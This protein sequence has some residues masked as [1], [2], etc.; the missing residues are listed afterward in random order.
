[1]AL[2]IRHSATA[3]R[4]HPPTMGHPNSAPS[5]ATPTIRQEVGTALESGSFSSAVTLND[6]EFDRNTGAT[7]YNNGAIV[8]K[9]LAGAVFISLNPE[10]ATIAPDGVITKVSDGLCQINAVGSVTLSIT[11]DLTSIVGGTTDVYTGAVSGCIAEHFS[12]QVDSRIDNTM[13]MN[14]NGLIYSTQD[15]DTPNYVRNV[16]LW[17]ANIDL[18]C[19]SPWNSRQGNRRAGTLVTPRHSINAAHYPLNNGDTMRFV[20][21]DGTVHTRTITGSVSITGTDL[22]INTLDS[23]LPAAISPCVVCPADW[24]DYAVQNHNN[25]P[26]CIGL[27]QQEKALVI[28]WNGNGSHLNPTDADRLIFHE[29]KIGGDSGNPAFLILNGVLVLTTVW[30]YGGAGS[31][32]PVASYITEL[33]AAIVTSD[34]QSE[35]DTG[36]TLTAANFS[37]FPTF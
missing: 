34:A 19:C 17:C 20:E 13:T 15:H 32:S 33:N 24:N 22:R 36:Y 27:D 14:A 23:D 21:A 16:N 10:V 18:T 28:D 26:A 30:H 7:Y 4:M 35:A 8:V 3:H 29:S 5:P 12:G 11:I 6:A 25:R 1:M 9:N 31:G 2:I 37:T